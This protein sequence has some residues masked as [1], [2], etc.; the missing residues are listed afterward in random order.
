MN[1]W[2]KRIHISQAMVLM[3]AAL[4][5]THAAADTFQLNFDRP[6]APGPSDYWFP[7]GLGGVKSS[8]EG[9]CDLDTQCDGNDGTPFSQEV[10]TVGGTEYWRN[11]VGD[12]ASGFV[13]EYYTRRGQATQVS[14][15]PYGLDGGGQER[16]FHGDVCQNVSQFSSNNKCGNGMD[17]LGVTNPIT[18]TG[19]GTNTP[20]KM[21]MHMILSM[22]GITMEILK[23]LTSTKPLITQ[24]ISS[25]ALTST[26][27][28]DM[29]G[30]SYSDK[31]TPIVIVNSQHID[32]PD[33]FVAGAG[34]FD[35]SMVEKSYVTAGRFT[36]TPGTG[37]NN[38][39]EGWD[40]VGSAFDKGVY[41]YI[42]GGGFDV[43]SADWAAYFDYAQNATVCSDPGRV[44]LDNCPGAP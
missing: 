15:L 1:K 34:D 13:F 32:D 24:S 5:G 8:Y 40:A 30:V 26:F 2:H 11:I 4:Y 44:G 27:I 22:N 10:V 31:N 41:D 17:P 3:L 43:Y 7:D 16:A 18:F 21:V 23:P 36:F 14:A 12:L 29:R 28:A 38:T 20:S 37:W 25:G 39:E 33:F 19:N 6:T 9:S 35:M 42:D